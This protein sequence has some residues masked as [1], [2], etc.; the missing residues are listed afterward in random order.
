MKTNSTNNFNNDFQ[1]FFDS[2]GVFADFEGQLKR[3]LGSYS[4]EINDDDFMWEF[5]CNN[6]EEFWRTMPLKPD[7]MLL[8]EYGIKYNPIVLTGVNKSHFD[9]A[10]EEKKIWWKKHFDYDRVI[11]CLAK[12]KPLHITTIN[13]VLVDDMSTNLKKWHKVGGR[14]IHHIDAITTITALKEIYNESD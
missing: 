9:F 2:D 6:K 5:I 13:D 12:D 11:T 8:W 3:M 1:L 14:G 7:A 4:H 10:A